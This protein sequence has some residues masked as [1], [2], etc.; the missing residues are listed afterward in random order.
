VI[1]IQL[2]DAEAK[3]L[4]RAFRHATDRKLLDRLHI[5]RLA[6]RGRKHKDIAADLGI[7]PSTVQ[8]WHNAYL[9]SG[10]DALRPRKAQSNAPAIPAPM[11]E[12]VRSK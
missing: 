12:E 2:T 4:E 11:A 8:R 7:T 1:R 5:V 10:L 6:H 9:G 3:S